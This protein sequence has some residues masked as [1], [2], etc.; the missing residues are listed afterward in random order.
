MNNTMEKKTAG[1]TERGG[2]SICICGGG[3][4]GHVVAGF[5]AAR[6]NN[7]VSVLT[8]HPERWQN[9]LMVE[10][11][12]REQPLVGQLA[13]VS[14]DPAQVISDAD[15]VVLCLP[16]YSIREVLLTI[17]PHLKPTAVVGSVVS[18]TGFFFQAM[19]VLLPSTPL[20]GLQRVPFIA[21]TVE[22][23]R[24]GRIMG[25][26]ESLCVAVEQTARKEVVREMVEMLFNTPTTL[27]ESH[28]E[29]SLS[30]SN[31]LLHPARLYTLLKDWHEG[32]VFDRVPLFYEEWTEEAAQLYIDMDSELHQLLAVLPVNP[33][34]IP[35]V[36]AYY[37]STDAASLARK[38]RSIQA[39]KGILMPMRP[40]EGGYAPDF[41]SR[42]FTE[43]FPYGLDVVRR[44]AY[45]KGVAT[46]HID[47]VSDWGASFL[48]VAF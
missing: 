18:S 39:F 4:L 36:L 41:H 15:V 45:Q 33:C 24:V 43:D 40:V 23:G 8:R 17:K 10:V 31:P 38:L 2:L 42:Y 34:N 3:N 25:F 19:D 28:Y 46:P 13:G 37:E 16:G 7:K 9:S 27:L 21:R 22:Y 12:D 30:N 1:L 47:K 48:P 35:T 20:F 44:L 6:T 5:V 26:K 11:P 29:A 32:I 14:S